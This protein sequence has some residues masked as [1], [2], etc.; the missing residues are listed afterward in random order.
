[1]SWLT[2]LITL[3]TIIYGQVTLDVYS[4]I[5]I[6]SITSLNPVPSSSFSIN[7]TFDNNYDTKIITSTYTSATINN[8]NDEYCNLYDTSSISL[9]THNPFKALNIQL[10]FLSSWIYAD[11]VQATPFFFNYNGPLNGA[12]TG[13]INFDLYHKIS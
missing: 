9:T 13:N 10:R 5:R 12:T 6:N 1:M 2:P 4:C 3:F 11:F 8:I 7:I